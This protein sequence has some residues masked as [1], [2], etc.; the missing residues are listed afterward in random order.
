MGM[1][2][3]RKKRINLVVVALFI[4]VCFLSIGFSAYNDS[5]NI[6]NAMATVTPDAKIQVTG[7]S[8]D[9]STN[10]GINN[11]FDYTDNTLTGSID[12]PNSNSTVTYEVVVTNLGNVEVG[13]ASITNLDPRLTYEITGYQEGTKL[14]DDSNPS[15]C[16]LNSVSTIYITLKYAQGATVTNSSIPFTATFNFATAYDI[17]YTHIQNTSGLQNSI[18]SGGTLSVTFTTDVPEVLYITTGSGSVINNY[19]YVTDPQNSNYKVLTIPNITSNITIDRYYEITYNLDSGTNNPNNPDR[20]LVS[21]N[22]NISNPTRQDYI[23]GGWYT[24]STL[25]GTQITSTSQ[26]SGNSVLYAKWLLTINYNLDGG[27]QPANQVYEF[28]SVINEPILAASKQY[29]IFDG[30]YNTAGNSVNNTSQ[31]TYQLRDLTAHWSVMVEKTNLSTSP[32]VVFTANNISSGTNSTNLVASRG[33]TYTYHGVNKTGATIN[34]VRV[35]INY[36]KKTGK[37]ENFVC[38]VY[39]NYAAYQAD[40]SHNAYLGTVNVRAS[41]GTNTATLD[42]SLTGNNQIT[43]DQEFVIL[44]SGAPTSSG[45]TFSGITIEFNP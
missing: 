12:L 29:Y 27:T 10:G 41:Q 7:A 24:S 22:V 45:A 11:M 8:F 1:N 6:T 37:S 25:Q 5:M 23:F 31:L 20:Y 14:C 42:I 18:V 19:T 32:S 33:D 36:Y 3:S 30:W 39:R 16:S 34:S 13:L 2:R 26:L 9:T 4:A 40:N 38:D 43:A 35:T 15:V 17:T 21:N 44:F 28:C